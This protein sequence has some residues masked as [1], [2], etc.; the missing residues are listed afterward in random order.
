LNIDFNKIE[1]TEEYSKA[2]GF[3]NSPNGVGNN[4]LFISGKPGVGKSVLIHYLDK[5]YGKQK[6]I[7]KVANT[8]NAALNVEGQTI[9]SFFGVPIGIADVRNVNVKPKDAQKLRALD[10]L[11][12]DEVSMVR[13]DLMDY[14]NVKLQMARKNNLP[15]GGV[16]VII[17]GDLFQL[18]P[19]ADNDESKMLR[20]MGYKGNYFFHSH[21]FSDLD[22]Y[23]LHLTKVKRTNDEKLKE[24]LNSIRLGENLK[25]SIGY[26]NRNHHGIKGEHLKKER[27]IVLTARNRTANFIN[28]KRLREIDAP[29]KLFTATIAGHF[30]QKMLTPEHLKLKVGAQVMITINDNLRNQYFNG[31]VATVLSFGGGEIR[32]K[33]HRTGRQVSL[34]REKW[35]SYKYDLI[36]GSLEKEEVGFFEQYPLCLG[37]AFSIHKSQGLT[38]S[39]VA[40]DLDDKGAFAAGQ[41]YVAL[42]R[43]VTLEHDEDTKTG[44]TLLTPLRISSVIVDNEVLKYYDSVVDKEI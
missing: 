28:D 40:I 37:W 13:A 17:V 43:L 31:D 18:S 16:K 44:L 7:V 27:D 6:N 19:V 39:S 22:Y 25:E 42:S 1:V 15:F 29:E 14:I 36:N 34:K 23:I 5:K 10:I 3:L 4:L 24:I 2:E 12:I 20:M 26:L 9:H 38:L 21:T 30:K 32:V 35:S 41:L 8:G 11:I 33:V